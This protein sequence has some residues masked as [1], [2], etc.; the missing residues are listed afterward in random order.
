MFMSISSN[1][2]FPPYL[3]ISLLAQRNEPKK[4]HPISPPSGSVAG[5]EKSGSGQ[6]A[7]FHS[8]QTWVAFS[9]N[10]PSRAHR[11]AKGIKSE[12]QDLTL[13]FY[14]WG[15]WNSGCPCHQKFVTSQWAVLAENGR[16]VRLKKVSPPRK[17]GSEVLEDWIPASAGMKILDFCN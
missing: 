15:D 5:S 8:A 9:L 10:L 3:F 13:I 4:G 16:V 12:K 1:Y 6:L 14:S 11:V 7:P 2:I 17:R